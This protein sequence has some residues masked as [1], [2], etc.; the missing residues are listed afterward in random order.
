MIPLS[1]GKIVYF[2]IV[3]VILN[4][5]TYFKKSWPNSANATTHRAYSHDEIL[6]VQHACRVS[7]DV[8]A[9]SRNH[10]ALWPPAVITCCP[11]FMC[12]KRLQSIL[13]VQASDTAP[14]PIVQLSGF[15]NSVLGISS[16]A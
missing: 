15:H 14:A 16:I 3:A 6:S 8:L 12:S 11:I 9:S 10:R 2:E 1:T 5:S 4:T 13:T 7:E